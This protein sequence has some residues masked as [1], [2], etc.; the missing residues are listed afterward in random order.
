MP[1]PLNKIAA[2]ILA[3]WGPKPKF[4]FALPYARA[5]LDLTSINDHYGTEPADEIVLR[6][7]S[8]AAPWRGE[9]ARNIKKEL[10]GLLETTE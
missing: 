8:N 7:L 4:I 10:H 1:R 3:D 6:F 5:M 9:V 2:E